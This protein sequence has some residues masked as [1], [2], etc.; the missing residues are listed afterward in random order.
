MTLQIQGADSLVRARP[1]PRLTRSPKL[2]GFRVSDSESD[3]DFSGRTPRKSPAVTVQPVSLASSRARRPPAA[4]SMARRCPTPPSSPT[5][6]PRSRCPAPEPPRGRGTVTGHRDGPDPRHGSPRPGRPDDRDARA[7][8][9]PYG[10]FEV[11]RLSDPLGWVSDPSIEP[12][13]PG[14][15]AN[16]T[17]SRQAF[18]ASCSG[19]LFRHAF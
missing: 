15:R 8:L 9:A 4:A 19:M 6:R 7:V 17:L 12:R 11:G 18:Q 16:G 3:L 13:K 1:L 2:V 14:S 10:A 5:G